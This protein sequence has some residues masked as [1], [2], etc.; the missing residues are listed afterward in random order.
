MGGL[1]GIQRRR[2]HF[3]E[4]AHA[5]FGAVEKG[6]KAEYEAM[7]RQDTPIIIGR[8]KHRRLVIKTTWHLECTMMLQEKL[9]SFLKTEGITPQHY[10]L[11]EVRAARLGGA[12]IV[13]GLTG[14]AVVQEYFDKPTVAELLSYFHWKAGREQRRLPSKGTILLCKKLTG[15]HDNKKLTPDKVQEAYR[16]LYR[17]AHDKKVLGKDFHPIAEQNVVVLGLTRD[18]KV[19]LALIDYP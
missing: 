3:M 19:R 4:R 7:K 5:L 9:L 18:A 10:S 15:T 12:T 16:E 13:P 6:R 1:K 2:R 14:S 11:H 8:G 17:H